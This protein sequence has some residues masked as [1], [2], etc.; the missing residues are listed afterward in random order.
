MENLEVFPSPEAVADAAHRYVVDVIERADDDRQVHIVLAG[1]STPERCYA[2][3]SNAPD[4]SWDHVHFWFG[5]ER[6]VG[7][8]HEESNYGMARRT[9]IDELGIPDERVHR[10]VGEIDPDVAAAEYEEEIQALV[11]LNADGQP[12]FD[13]VL[14][15][16]GDDGHTASLF[17]GT[18]ALNETSR[19]AVANEVPQQ[20]RTRITLTYPAINAA[21]HVL[22]IITGDEKADA[23]R[24]VVQGDANAAPAAG[25]RPEIGELQYFVD[26][27]AA[28]R[29]ELG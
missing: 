25:I 1:G 8:E 2:L 3:L 6:T 16:L 13:I 12:M 26:E 21:R 20:R 14:L 15:G 18:Q 23:L 4:T 19:I 7:P 17:P 27:S 24:N 10:M 9:L 5:D 29:I 22:F 28:S 11:P